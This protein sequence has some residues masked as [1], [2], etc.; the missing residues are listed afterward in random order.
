MGFERLPMICI[1][2]WG[3]LDRSQ[4]EFSKQNLAIYPAIPILQ[5]SLPVTDT[6]S[7]VLEDLLADFY[8]E[9]LSARSYIIRSSMYD[10]PS[11]RHLGNP[12]LIASVFNSGTIPCKH[13]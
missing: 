3:N 4:G 6:G 8:K 10:L 9:S 1:E 13:L 5:K 2:D 12:L 11:A 7:Q